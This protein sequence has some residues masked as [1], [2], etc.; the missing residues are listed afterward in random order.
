MLDYQGRSEPI[1]P[2][3]IQFR[4][5]IRLYYHYRRLL[6]TTPQAALELDRSTWLQVPYYTRLC[7]T[8]KKTIVD[9]RQGQNSLGNQGREGKGLLVL[10]RSK[11]IQTQ[12]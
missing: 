11:A 2:L 9:I 8:H 10:W 1:L 3:T 7:Y 6:Y 5:S 4:N 12:L